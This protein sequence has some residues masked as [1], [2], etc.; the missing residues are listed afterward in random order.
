MLDGFSPDAV[1]EVR[2]RL[3]DVR[4][5]GVR[6]LFAIESGSRAWGFPS[7]D[8]DYDCRFVY[9]RSIEDHLKLSAERDVIEFPI[10]GEIDTGGWDLKKALLLAL[11]GN[12]VIAEW[13]DSPL[14]YEEVDG[15]RT[16]LR[17][18]LEKIIVP[19]QV[20]RHYAGLLR[21][22]VPKD[23]SDT[24]LKR[25]FYALR[26][27]LSLQ[28]MEERD[29]RELPPMNMA[30]LLEKV[31]IDT[32][33]RAFI[34]ELVEQKKVTREMGTGPMPA[35]IQRYLDEVNARYAAMSRHRDE[36]DQDSIRLRHAL[37]ESFYIDVV[38][39]ANAGVTSVTT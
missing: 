27:A 29:Y 2:R 7:P 3:D 16:R 19:V 12:A 11:K 20:A 10:E 30:R 33:L 5:S 23:A 9:V 35:P 28:F 39:T 4:M 13:A 36:I 26:P 22:H 38:T 1:C 8:S 18:L 32:E 14:C 37:A 25:L 21:Y 34:D 31:G 24:K 17:T 15:F 6:I